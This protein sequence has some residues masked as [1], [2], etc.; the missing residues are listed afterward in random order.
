M[1]K[2]NLFF[3]S[4]FLLSNVSLIYATEINN[5]TI[6]QKSVSNISYNITNVQQYGHS[7]GYVM[8]SKNNREEKTFTGTN[9]YKAQMEVT[10]NGKKVNINIMYYI[11]DPKVTGSQETKNTPNNIIVGEEILNEDSALENQN[12]K[13]SPNK[14][15]EKL[16][17]IGISKQ[18]FDREMRLHFK[19]IFYL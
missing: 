12:L 5:Q 16:E 18:E 2:V 10:K 17:S 6:T 9:H 13:N 7:D 4:M 19:T 1:K 14:E 11:T 15:L 3:F 8:K